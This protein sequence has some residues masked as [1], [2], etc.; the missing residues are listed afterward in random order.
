M[1]MRPTRSSRPRTLRTATVCRSPKLPRPPGMKDLPARSAKR[2]TP[3]S[4]RTTQC[5]VMKGIVK[6]ARIS[7]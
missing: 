3:L 1:S 4:S 2:R 5:M 7:L 6:S